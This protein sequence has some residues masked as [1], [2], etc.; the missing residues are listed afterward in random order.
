[1]KFSRFSEKKWY[2]GAVVACIGV[3]FYV[4]LTHFRPIL[5]AV[6]IFLG[7]FKPIFVGMVFAYILNPLARFFYHTVFRKMKVGKT[8]WGF[9]V[10]LTVLSSL[11]VLVFLIGS[12]IPQLVQ[13]VKTFSE[14]MDVYA[15]TLIKMI[16]G[17]PLEAIIDTGSLETYSQNALSTIT[18][19]VGKNAG[20]ILNQAADSGKGILST[21]IAFIL[22]VYLLI[23]KKRVMSGWWRFVRSLSREGTTRVMDFTLRCD[24][25]FMSYL[26]QSLLDA[27]IIGIINAVFMLI[28][29]MQYIGLVSVVVAVTN[30]IPNFG[31]LIGASIGGFVLL[32]VNP[33]H[34]LL[35]LGFCVILQFCDAYILKPKLFSNSL[36]VSGLLIL[37][38]SI[39]LGNMFGILGM[40]LAIPAAAILS[41]IYHEYFLPRR[42]QV[43]DRKNKQEKESTE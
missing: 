10:G 25:I 19:F 23:D 24:V 26:G 18:E 37:A 4:L 3:A 31:P 13:S 28:F 14:N 16:Q 9:A 29:R 17:S 36:G 41:I 1:M 6:G 21:V 38:V 15:A 12:L 2:N 34:A 7:Y 43:Q 20:T 35:F 22:A 42:E 30:L 32:L 11:I 40:L 27:V 33:V 39:V 8:R 5:S